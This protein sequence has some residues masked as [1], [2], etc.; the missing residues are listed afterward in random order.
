M[1]RY[2]WAVSDC[3]LCGEALQSMQL[4]GTQ[5]CE[6]CVTL[7]FTVGHTPPA[8]LPDGGQ[9]KRGAKTTP[10]QARTEC[11]RSSHHAPAPTRLPPLS[12][13]ALE[14]ASEGSRGRF[15]QSKL[16]AMRAVRPE[17]HVN[18]RRTTLFNPY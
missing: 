1:R 3:V 4:S 17:S 5:N 8:S 7:Y 6:L 14:C 15:A 16:L 12:P 2:Y 13:Q 10:S 11:A 18:R 9:A